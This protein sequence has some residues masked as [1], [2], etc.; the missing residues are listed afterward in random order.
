MR[1]YVGLGKIKE[2]RRY[3]RTAG[4]AVG[5]CMRMN[6]IRQVVRHKIRH[7]GTYVYVSAETETHALTGSPKHKLINTY[8]HIR[9]RYPDCHKDT[10]TRAHARTHT[11]IHTAGHK[12]T[13]ARTYTHAHTHPK[14]LE[15]HALGKGFIGRNQ[16]C[17][18]G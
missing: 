3:N 18:L 16:S 12:H 6:T 8:L 2:S 7:I 17:C 5:R 13:H 11:H 4:W 15:T 9:K 1:Q 10:Q 14:E